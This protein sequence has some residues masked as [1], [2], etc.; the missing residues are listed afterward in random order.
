M[1]NTWLRDAPA[2]FTDSFAYCARLTDA[3]LDFYD[4]RS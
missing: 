4:E 1:A 2:M 3:D